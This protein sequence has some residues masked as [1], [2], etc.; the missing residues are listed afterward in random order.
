MATSRLAD[1]N[2]LLSGM[3][4]V[5]VSLPGHLSRILPEARDR[6]QQE[7]ILWRDGIQE[8]IMVDTMLPCGAD[9][10]PE[11]AFASGASG[12]ELWPAHIE[13]A[14]ARIRGGYANLAEGA[15]V[16]NNL[17]CALSDLTGGSV[18]T[19]ALGSAQMRGW[20]RTGYLWAQL[21]LWCKAGRVTCCVPLKSC[22]DMYG[23]DDG[24][25]RGRGYPIVDTWDD[26]ATGQKFI[27]LYD[28]WGAS[29]EALRGGAGAGAEGDVRARAG[30]RWHNPSTKGGIPRQNCFGIT[31]D[32]WAEHFSVVHVCTVCPDS[33]QRALMR[34]TIDASASTQRVDRAWRQKPADWRPC[35]TVACAAPSL[36]HVSVSIDEGDDG[37]EQMGSREVELGFVLVRAGPV[38]SRGKARLRDVVSVVPPRLHRD[39]SLP[40]AI[41]VRGEEQGK[42][43]VVPMATG[44]GEAVGRR[45]RVCCSAKANA[46]ACEVELTERMLTGKTGDVEGEASSESEG[47][48]E[49]L[50]SF[51]G[52]ELVDDDAASSKMRVPALK[53]PGLRPVKRDAHSIVLECKAAVNKMAALDDE[54]ASLSLPGMACEVGVD[55]GTEAKVAHDVVSGTCQA[56]EASNRHVTLQTLPAG[57]GDGGLEGCKIT[58]SSASGGWKHEGVVGSYDTLTRRV[59]LK[60]ALKA[61]HKVDLH[62]R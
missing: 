41:E 56:R 58:L 38:S 11:C 36:L 39:A 1:D 49:D 59:R 20:K 29:A 13:R 14:F 47:S 61:E 37:K 54:Y 16:G 42:F 2:W 10:S 46:G 45:F 23:F 62:T 34:A 15:R 52:E 48:D 28:A 26:R 6:E 51:V 21:Q 35:F 5:A 4:C 25:Y 50:M 22:M 24:L 30:K 12:M 60:G 17:A 43:V 44:H 33:W 3:A 19:H 7:V 55:E 18:Q 40:V 9:G 27:V 53:A 32:E 31:F 8:S 57:F